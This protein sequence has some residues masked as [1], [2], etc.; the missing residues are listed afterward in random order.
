MRGVR[1]GLEQDLRA[2]D[3]EFAGRSELARTLARGPLLKELH[4]LRQRY[5]EDLD[6]ASHGESYFTLFKARFVPN[7]LYLLDEPEAPLSPMRQIGFLAMVRRLV[8]EEGAQFIIA[9]HSPILIA[10]PEAAILSF[11]GGVVRPVRYEETDH[12]IVTRGFLNS[13]E[14]FL[15]EL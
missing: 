14:R 1:E 11:D 6:H 15:R 12:Y 2:V 8:A 7:G 13:P 4:A 3:E 9:T 10:L 5:G